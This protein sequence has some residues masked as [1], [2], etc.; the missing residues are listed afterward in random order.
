[1]AFI[2]GTTG[3]VRAVLNQTLVGQEVV[4]VLYFEGTADPTQAELLGLAETIGEA[5]ADTT[6]PG[7][8]ILEW[9]NEE[10]VLES[11]TCTSV[12]AANGPQAEASIGIAG[13]GG[14]GSQA[15]NNTLAVVASLRTAL[16]GRSFRGRLYLAGIDV[17]AG[18]TD[19]TNHINSAAVTGIGEGLQHVFDAANLLANA[20]VPVVASYYTRPV[21]DVPG[22][23]S[24]PRA[25][26]I[27]TPI[28]SVIV[29]SL[30]GSQRRR[31]LEA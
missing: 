18:Q 15:V 9:C 11:V 14:S 25:A 23:P 29:R 28:T 4:N 7:T 30:L 5:W 24:V 19:D 6:A 3:L 20:Y 21:P 26:A 12:H 22:D 10:L 27:T 8:G 1:M 13:Q 16:S 17:S 31:R 2:P